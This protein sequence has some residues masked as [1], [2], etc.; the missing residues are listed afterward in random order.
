M[1]ITDT[2]CPRGARTRACRAPQSPGCAAGS[3]DAERWESWE[4]LALS[5]TWICRDQTP[6]RAELALTSASMSYI[7]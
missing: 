7:R 4:Q 1:L 3:A 5:W 6:T 2:P